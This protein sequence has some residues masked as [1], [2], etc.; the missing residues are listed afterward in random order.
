[1]TTEQLEVWMG[2]FGRQY[3]IRNRFMSDEAFNEFYKNR[4]GQT[5]LEINKEFLSDLDPS[6]PILEVGANIGNQLRALRLGGFESLFGLE[7][8]K[9]CV[10]E[11][12]KL[13]PEVDIFQGSAF[14]IPFKNNFF[15]MVFTNNVLIHINPENL[16]NVMREMYRVS[17]RFIVGFEYYS[18]EMTEI[19]YRGKSNLLWK[20]DYS[21]LFLTLFP[22]LKLIRE[23]VFD[24]LDEPGNRDKIFVLEK[25]N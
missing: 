6:L 20:G 21:K 4:Y 25:S 7:I 16:P 12:K 17:K 3:T 24:C 18:D 23:K 22:D 8:Q 1:M 19:K 14:D 15:N 13:N 9:S 11:S 10:V 5:R 2:D